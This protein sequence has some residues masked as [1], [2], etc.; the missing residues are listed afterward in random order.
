MI[1]YFALIV[2]LC[3][4]S[5]CTEQKSDV[6]RAQNLFD[7][8]AAIAELCAHFGE[9]PIVIKKLQ[10]DHEVEEARMEAYDLC[11]DLRTIME[12]YNLD[13]PSNIDKYQLVSLVSA[14]GTTMEYR[15]IDS[16]LHVK[17][18]KVLRVGDEIKELVGQ[19][20]SESLMAKDKEEIL[21]ERGEGYSLSSTRIRRGKDPKVMTISVLVEQ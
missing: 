18:L 3:L 11:S 4:I 20:S 1:R 8:D 21:I 6:L 17:Y 10:A 13:R 19:R 14:S 12:D 7:A 9:S 2:L 16:N 15:A 5:S